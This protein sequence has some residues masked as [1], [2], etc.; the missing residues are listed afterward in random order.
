[1]SD[2]F[3]P[4]VHGLIAALMIYPVKSLAGISVTEARLLETGLEW[5]RHWMVVDADGLFLTQREC[6]RM[7]LVQPRITPGALELHGPEGERLVVP[8][9]APGPLRRV[10]VWDDTLDALDMGKDAALWLQQVLGEP[11]V[12]LVRFAPQVQ[13]PCSTRWTGGA[14]SH[15]QFAD[16]Y[17]VLVTTEASMDPLNAR[18]AAAGLAPVG[19]NRFRPNLVLGALDAHDEDH[20]TVLE[21]EMDAESQVRPRLAL[22]KPCARCPIPNIDPVTAQTHPGVGDAL[23]AYRQDARVN[24]AI[25]FGMNAIVQAGAGAVLRV[26]Q[27]VA[28]SY[29][30]E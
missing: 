29:G 3:T 25:T 19:I 15:T 6:P 10:Q 1:M 5:D 23:M 27:S 14:P 26:G 8:L 18:L 13:R 9:Q 24:G 4:D 17:P 16:G 12:R 20:L 28:A 30:F 22:V 7:A 21:V 11:G 2:N